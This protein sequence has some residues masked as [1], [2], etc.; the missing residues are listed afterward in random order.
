MPKLLPALPTRTL[1]NLSQKWLIY[2]ISGRWS[3]WE[4][5]KI[6][7]KFVIFLVLDYI[8][9]EKKWHI[10]F[11]TT[12]QHPSRLIFATW[13]NFADLV[14]LH[15]FTN[16]SIHSILVNCDT[17]GYMICIQD[18]GIVFSERHKLN[19][20]PGTTCY[21]PLMALPTCPACGDRVDGRLTNMN[22]YIL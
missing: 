15:Y 12:C 1:T 3:I 5:G 13:Y 19:I 9:S 10:T 7:G 17:H 6:L 20:S 4:D 2:L 16:G 18:L 11:D 14:H 8:I 21:Q 22:I